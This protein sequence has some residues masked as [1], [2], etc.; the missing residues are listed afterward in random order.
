MWSMEPSWRVEG[1]MAGQIICWESKAVSV[2]S[3]EGGREAVGESL[4][5]GGDA[6]M[7]STNA[8]NVVSLCMEHLLGKI[9]RNHPSP[10]KREVHDRV[11][12]NFPSDD[13][14]IRMRSLPI[15]LPLTP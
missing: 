8:T 14:S 7:R 1:K 15:Y 13:Y 9:P 5:D 10:P 3:R 2:G 11:L 6:G 12:E 4:D